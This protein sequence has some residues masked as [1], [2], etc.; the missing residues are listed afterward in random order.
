MNSKAEEYYDK[1]R[2]QADRLLLMAARSTD[3]QLLKEAE[4]LYKRLEAENLP[5][6]RTA[7]R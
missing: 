7:M 6:G 1:L 4:A 2:R 5:L 3:M